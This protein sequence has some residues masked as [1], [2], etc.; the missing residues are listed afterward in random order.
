[1]F[2]VVFKRHYR[3]LEEVLVSETERRN[4]NI[5]AQVALLHKQ[6]EIAKTER[7]CFEL[8]IVNDRELPSCQCSL[9]NH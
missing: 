2:D 6:Q 4:H 9:S 3:Q 1:M 5:M 8:L 7:K